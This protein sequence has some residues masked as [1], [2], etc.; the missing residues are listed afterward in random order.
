[1]ECGSPFPTYL[2]SVL[3]VIGIVFCL[4]GVYWVMLILCCI[5]CIVGKATLATETIARF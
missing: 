3:G 5:C 4:F 1:M 2:C